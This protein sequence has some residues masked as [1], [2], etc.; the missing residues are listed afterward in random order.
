MERWETGMNVAKVSK[1]II[2]RDK[3]LYISN[4]ELNKQYEENC[5]EVKTYNIKDLNN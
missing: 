2:D 3:N 5:G 4:E 1:H